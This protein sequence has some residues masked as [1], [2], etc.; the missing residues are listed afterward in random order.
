VDGIVERRLHVGLVAYPTSGRLRHEG[1]RLTAISTGVRELRLRRAGGGDVPEDVD[2]ALYDAVHKMQWRDGAK[3]LMF[4]VGDAPPA[5]RG[6]VPAFD[7]S[8]QEA[9]NMQ[10]VITTVRCG[11]DNDTAAAWQKIA[12]I[13]RGEF[14]T[15]RQDGGV[16]QVATPYDDKIRELSNT[17]D[18]S[19]VIYGDGSVHAAYRRD[20]RAA[21][22]ARPRRSPIAPRGTARA[23]ATTTTCSRRSQRLAL[24]R[25][26]R[27]G[28]AA[29]DLKGDAEG[30]AQGR[31]RAPRRRGGSGEEG[32]QELQQKRAEYIHSNKGAGPAGFDDAVNAT[33]TRE[34]K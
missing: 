29:A 32:D 2:A 24:D 16:N 10:I 28:Q 26:P 18:N 7:V 14:S 13:G 34:L 17:V 22:A 1:L 33:V 4:L 8:A 20:G 12:T 31:A 9:A 5:T 27:R 25:Q 6:D 11:Q 30:C 3:R 19:A 23:R 15:I 21:N